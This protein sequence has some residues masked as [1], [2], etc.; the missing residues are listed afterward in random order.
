MKAALRTVLLGLAFCAGLAAQQDAAVLAQQGKQA[1]AER[2]FS[3]AATIYGRLVELIPG[4]PGL[5]L[6]QGMALAMAGRDAEAVPPLEK[7]VSI[8][9]KIYPAWLFLG[10]SHLRLGH[11]DKAIEPLEKAVEMQPDDPQAQRMLGEALRTLG[12]HREA[13]PHLRKLAA[14]TPDD[15]SVWAALIESYQALASEAFSS[16]QKAAPESAYMVRLIA[17]A[18]FAQRQYPS[19]LYLYRLAIERDP[20]LRGP[21]AAV[22]EIYRRTNH[23]DWAATEQKAE[24]ELGAPPC[25]TARLECDYLA[26]KLDT[27]AAAKGRDAA[28]LFWRAKA[29][30]SLA[31]Q[32]FDKLNDLPDTAQKHELLAALLA[33]QARHADAADHWQKALDLE[34]GNPRYQ[35][36]YA[37]QLYLAR[38]IEKAKP[39]IEK[40]HAQAPND[41]QWNFFLGDMKLQAQDAAGAVP[42]LEKAVAADASLLP[43]HHALGRAYM[44]VEQPEKAIPHLKAALELDQDGSLHYQLAQAYIRTGQRDLAREPLETSRKMQASVQA[45]QS[46]AQEMAITAPPAP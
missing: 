39:L 25:E 8:E 5:L 11:P 9:P 21:H 1:L 31:D 18:R 35:A 24:A 37:T 2:R 19:A 10:G 14:A 23:P 3:D 15:A 13:L 45:Q 34:P 30:S 4:N 38:D 42:L 29:L 33:D 43:A 26:G 36:A 22:A 17:D 6:N 7:A 32:A 40:L 20:K 41:P 27:V 16:L 12:R 44:A 28:A 46:A